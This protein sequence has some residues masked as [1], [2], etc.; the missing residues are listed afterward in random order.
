MKTNTLLEASLM[1]WRQHLVFHCAV[2]VAAMSVGITGVATAKQCDFET[3]ASTSTRD[4]PPPLDLQL[5]ADIYLMR[6][7]EDGPFGTDT[8]V[9]LTNNAHGDGF[10]ALSPDGKKI[11]LDTNRLRL[12]GERINTNDL[13]VMNTDG[14]EETRLTRGSTASWSPDGKYIVFHRS[15]SGKE[16]R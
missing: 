13:F 14:T 8:T 15:A 11:V 12:A 10:P 16:K 2:L 1:N 7:N 6:M 3:I 9:R 4:N 5:A